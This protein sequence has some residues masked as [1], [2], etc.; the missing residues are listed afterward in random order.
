MCNVYYKYVLWRHGQVVRQKPA[1]LLFPSSNL[2]VAFFIFIMDV[3]SN[4]NNI[5]TPA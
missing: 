3:C 2:G 1:K 5:E 4:F